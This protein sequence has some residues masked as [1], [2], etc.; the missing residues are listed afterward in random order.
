MVVVTAASLQDSAADTR[1]I[2]RVAAEHPPIRKVWVDG[3]YRQHLV[4]HAATLGIDMEITARKPP[5]PSGGRLSGPTA[6][7]APPPPG[8]RLRKAVSGR[9]PHRGPGGQGHTP[10]LRTYSG[11][12]DTVRADGS[13]QC[14]RREE[15]AHEHPHSTHRSRD[16]G[17]IPVRTVRAL[18]S[19][20]H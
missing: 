14:R 15:P 7:S 4:E 17:P 8:P 11:A 9:G 20:L 3:G 12:E 18:S 16:L 6:G 19:S 2:D 5:S 1:L 10:Y 13:L